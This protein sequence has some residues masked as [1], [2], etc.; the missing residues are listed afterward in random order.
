MDI[1]KRLLE[2]RRWLHQHPETAMQEYETTAYIAERLKAAGIPYRLPGK[3]GVIA[4]LTVDERLPVIALRAEMDALPLQEET[5]LSFSSV[6]PGKMHACGHDANTAILLCLAEVLQERKEELSC[7]VRFL[8]EPAEETGEGAKYMIA[9][10]ALENP[11]PAAVLIFHFGNQDPCAME[12]QKSITT[13][14]IGGLRITATGKVSH[15]S[16]YH[17]GVDALYGA[18][19]LVTEVRAINETFPAR[20]PFILGL[21]CME[22]GPGRNSV[23][24]HARLEGSLRTF[25]NEDFDGVLKELQTRMQ[26]I[27]QETGVVFQT[28]ITRR[29]PPMINDPLLVE[30]G[31][32]I[33]REIFGGSF[34]LGEH[35]F[36]VG[37]NAAY[38]M[39]KV[40]GMRVVFLAG[41][42]DREN[43]PV[44]NP[45]FDIDEAVMIKALRFL[46]DFAVRFSE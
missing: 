39:E 20:Y 1:E 18:A 12:I 43:Y 41:K 14:A 5:G 17:D 29:I 32:R 6:Y 40:P 2:T 13:A 33:G 25:S 21:G 27:R 46:E 45:C 4:D 16:Q 36:L 30:K 8:F 11:V 38:Y 28:E 37:D 24:G 26:A 9:H 42:K 10:G 44:H 15:F 3:T 22:A 19:R 34:S 31:S 7:N 23:C 35:P